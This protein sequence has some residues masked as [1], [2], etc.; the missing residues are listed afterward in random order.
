[1]MP[2][3]LD[4]ISTLVTGSTL[5]V[6]TTERT[7]APRS[8]VASLVGSMPV[9]AP[10]RMEYPHAAAVRRTMPAAAASHFHRDF[11]IPASCAT[12]GA[13]RDTSCDDLIRWK[14]C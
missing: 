6:A 7:I 11:L 12:S 10:L 5:P 4:L 8:T 3:A 14:V 9:E 1:M 2:F 13:G